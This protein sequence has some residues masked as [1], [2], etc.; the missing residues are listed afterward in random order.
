[1]CRNPYLQRAPVHADALRAAGIGHRQ[2]HLQAR[3]HVGRAGTCSAIKAARRAGLEAAA[4]GTAKQRLEEVTEAAL[5][6]TAAAGGATPGQDLAQVEL[7]SLAA[8]KVR[9]GPE[10]LARPVA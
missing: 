3:A 7:V 8:S 5:P 2:R 1:A 9:R 4:A 6:R 10:L